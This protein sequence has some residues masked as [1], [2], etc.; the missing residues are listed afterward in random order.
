[1]TKLIKFIGLFLFA[2]ILLSYAI[3]FINMGYQTYNS[4]TLYTGNVIAI[5]CLFLIALLALVLSCVNYRKSFLLW[6]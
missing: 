5:V 1:M 6:K 4:V 2:T 3:F